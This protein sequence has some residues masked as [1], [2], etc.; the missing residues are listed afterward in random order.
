M[1]G[2][3]SGSKVEAAEFPAGL[4]RDGRAR[5]R[6]MGWSVGA[7]RRWSA[8]V[9]AS[10]WSQRRAWACVPSLAPSSLALPSALPPG[11]CAQAALLL[12]LTMLSWPWSQGSSVRV[13][14]LLL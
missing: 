13:A 10:G 3:E 4:G 1:S 8:H 9:G 2:S 6:K 14:V 5:G 11:H 12:A 7:P